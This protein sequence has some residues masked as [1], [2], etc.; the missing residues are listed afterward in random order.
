LLKEY[1]FM[2]ALHVLAICALATIG[3]AA[4]AQDIDWQ[5]VDAVLGRKAAVTGDVHRYG[6][7]RTDLNVTLDGITIKPAL[8][9]GGWVAFKPARGGA[10]VMGD[11][12][13]LEG[14]IT[15][16]MTKL[17]ENG[18][19]ITAVHNHVLRGT[20]ATFYMHI[21]GHGDPEKLATA[22]RTAL[23]ES[24]TPLQA[25]AGS[26]PVIDLDTDQL[27]DIIGAKGQATGGVYQFGIPRRDLITEGGMQI[28][29]EVPM[30]VATAINFQPTGGGKAAITGDF[31]LTGDEVNPVIKALRTNGIEVTAI[32]SH[33]LTE[34]PRL[35]FLHFWANDDAMTLAR[36]LRAGIDKTK[37]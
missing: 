15:P 8:A 30:G 10:M 27:D 7:P 21:G 4:E 29:P 14:E 25:P 5:K 33:M 13:L 19:E 1:M 12:V 24:K 22:I 20:P 23:A 37:S 2:R 6:F 35:I 26:A 18:L 32:H 16:V 28:A 3:S 9:L 36:G 17:I 11:L 31:V 34:Q